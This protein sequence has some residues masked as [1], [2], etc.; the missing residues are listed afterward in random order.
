MPA[1]RALDENRDWTFGRGLQNYARNNLAILVDLETYLQTYFTECFFDNDFGLPWF[2][3]IGSK[4]P[5]AVVLEV[6]K[7]ITQIEGITNVIDVGFT[8]N[9][10]KKRKLKIQYV[11]DTIYTTQNTGTVEI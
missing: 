4:N 1:F 8:F 3:L 10:D 11:V 2:N 9:E 6:K 7:G 5:E